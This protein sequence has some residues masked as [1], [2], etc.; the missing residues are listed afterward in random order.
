MLIGTQHDAESAGALMFERYYQELYH[1]FL[2][3]LS[4]RDRAADLVQESYARVLSL[5]YRGIEIREPRAL[6]YQTGKRL[7]IENARRHQAEA[8]MIEALEESWPGDVPS[9][10][11]NAIAR[12]QLDR[13]LLRL[14]RMPRKRREVFILV[15][16]YGYTHA[17]AGAHLGISAVAVEKHVV[18]AVLDL[19]GLEGGDAP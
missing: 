18:R 15:R 9:L 7:A 3:S 4:N 5:E 8:R 17:E 10:E 14:K 13:L 2:R 11:R 6:L 16:M 1:F 19:A 12:Q